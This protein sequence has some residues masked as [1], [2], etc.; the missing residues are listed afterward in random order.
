VVNTPVSF[1]GERPVPMSA[2]PV[3]GEGTDDVL[4]ELGLNADEIATLRIGKVI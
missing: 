3:L 4:R 2:P 1:D